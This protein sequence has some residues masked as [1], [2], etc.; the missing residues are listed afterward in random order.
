VKRSRTKSDGIGY[1][2]RRGRS[3]VAWRERKEIKFKDGNKNRV[4]SRTEAM[5]K[6]RKVGEG[7][8]QIPWRW[9]EITGPHNRG[10]KKTLAVFTGKRQVEIDKS[11]T[12]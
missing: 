4:S 10:Q 9:S 8:K 3:F 12:Q 5:R 11:D 6:G 1:R 7:G 2:S